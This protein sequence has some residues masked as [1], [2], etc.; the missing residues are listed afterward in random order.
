VTL[1][2]LKKKTF[3]WFFHELMVR[4]S[5]KNLLTRIDALF[6]RTS[7]GRRIAVSAVTAV[8]RRRDSSLIRHLKRRLEQRVELQHQHAMQ[9]HFAPMTLF[10]E[11]PERESLRSL[12]A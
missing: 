5:R 4:L 7:Y 6:L 1:D 2:F 10:R 8:A 9:V 12:G 3:R 11:F